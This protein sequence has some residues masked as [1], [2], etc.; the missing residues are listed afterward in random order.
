MPRR[1]LRLNRASNSNSTLSSDAGSSSAHNSSHSDSN[2]TV[3][4]DLPPA[5]NSQ[6]IEINDTQAPVG[7][8]EDDDVI[9]IQP[10]IETIDLCTQ[11]A[12]AFRIPNNEVI[13]VEDSPVTQG[14]VAGPMRNSRGRARAAASPYVVPAP[15]T[16]KQLD[17]NDSMDESATQAVKIHCPI[18]LES[19][20]GRQPVSTICGHLFCKKCLTAALQNAKK[21]PMCK[22]TLKMTSFHD[23]FLGA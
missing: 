21:C 3:D 9:L 16:S 13:E 5:D 6:V 8:E 1:S 4:Y 20:V 2:D 17:F 18:C 7:N 15:K 23:I 19:I 14:N 10:H 22:K 12:P 11:V